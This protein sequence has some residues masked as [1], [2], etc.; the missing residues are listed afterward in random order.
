MLIKDWIGTIPLKLLVS[1]LQGLR[2]GEGGM[3]EPRLNFAP[4]RKKEM[5]NFRGIVPIQSLISIKLSL[6]WAVD[7]VSMIKLT[8]PCIME[9]LTILTILI[10]PLVAG[11]HFC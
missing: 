11:R 6:K 9:S 2:G 1:F 3:I 4:P 5:S 10:W 8:F 7:E